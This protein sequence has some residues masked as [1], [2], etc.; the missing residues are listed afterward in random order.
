VALWHVCCGVINRWRQRFGNLRQARLQ[1]RNSTKFYTTTVKMPKAEVG[2][3]KYLNNKLKSKGLQRLRWYCQVYLAAPIVSAPLT[4]NFSRS[5][6]AKCAT[7][8]ASRCT[9]SPN[10]TLDKCSS[11]AKTP[12]NTSMITATSSS[13]TSCN[14]SAHRTARRRSSSTTS[15]RNILRIRSMYT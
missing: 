8:T 14:S 3:T 15:T 11:S 5:A 2:S 13:A 9:R 4:H 12:K 1:I 10:R 6:S 7:R